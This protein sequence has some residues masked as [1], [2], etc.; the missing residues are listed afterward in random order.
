LNS[1]SHIGDQTFDEICCFIIKLGEAAHRYGVTTY[2]LE[3][4]LSQV[5]TALGIQG[6]FA[7][8]PMSISFNFLREGEQ[9]QRSHFARM[10]GVDFNMARL[11]QI[12][13]LMDQIASG[14]VTVSDGPARLKKIDHMPNPYGPLMLALAYGLSGAGFAVL[15]SSSWCDVLFGG[16]LSLVVYAIVF[17]AGRLEWVANMLEPLAALT[18]SVLANGLALL[19]PG[20]NPFM[21]TMCAVIVLVPGFGLVLGLGELSVN[22]IVSGASRL[23]SAIVVTFKLFFGAVI[24]TM[25]AGALW[26]IPAVVKPLAT[27]PFWTWVFLAFLL[28]GLAMVFQVR[29]RDLFLPLTVG[30]LTWGGVMLGNMVGYWQGSFLGALIM[31]VWGNGIALRLH[32]PAAVILLPCVLILV[33]GASAYRG[34]SILSTHGIVASLEAEIKVFVIACAIIGGLLIGNFVVS[35]KQPKKTVQGNG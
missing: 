35:P 10:P 22:H 21:V 9:W 28:V 25:I 30:M 7:V 26:S 3:S 18:I 31:V 4:F 14:K 11:T 34:L 20:S 1:D 8:T 23:L 13:E 2:R 12:G 24:G 6:Q 17:L 5:S 27:S 16:L 29:P 15:M 33:P 32:R 19:T